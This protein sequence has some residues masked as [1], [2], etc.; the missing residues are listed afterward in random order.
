M[1]LCVAF[2]ESEHGSTA[3]LCSMGM[4]RCLQVQCH[5]MQ[6]SLAACM[7]PA[8][9]GMS[10][11]QARLDRGDGLVVCMA[12]QTDQPCCWQQ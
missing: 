8:F 9:F 7:V 4:N 6:Q 3:C 5:A 2:L 12:R 10:M 11:Q 1:N